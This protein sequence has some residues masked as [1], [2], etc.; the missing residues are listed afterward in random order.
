MAA[1]GAGVFDDW[2]D[3]PVWVSVVWVQVKRLHFLHQSKRFPLRITKVGAP[4]AGGVLRQERGA[5][6][7]PRPP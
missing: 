3:P 7:P 4:G 6:P 2:G 5:S 1:T